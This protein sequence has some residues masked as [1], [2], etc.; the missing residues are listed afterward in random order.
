[1]LQKELKQVF[2]CRP[3]WLFVLWQEIFQKISFMFTTSFCLSGPFLFLSVKEPGDLLPPSELQL[4]SRRISLLKLWELWGSYCSVFSLLH[5]KQSNRATEHLLSPY[6][7]KSLCLLRQSS[8]AL[9]HTWGSAR[10]H[11]VCIHFLLCQSLG[12]DEDP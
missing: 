1:M 12:V 7:V 2:P 3:V 4:E 10:R 11:P 5:K 6:P 8:K 9:L